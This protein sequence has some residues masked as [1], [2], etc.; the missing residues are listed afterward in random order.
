MKRS[1]LQGTLF[2]MA[3]SGL[4]AAH[5]RA[6]ASSPAGQ[7][8]PKAVAATPSPAPP[9]E[10]AAAGA[11]ARVIY[12]SGSAVY[13]D[14][15]REEGLREGELLQVVRDGGTIA[16][17][18]VAY[19]STHRASCSIVS[20]SA[21]L[22]VGDSV[23]YAPAAGAAGP[24]EV[25]RP[26]PGNGGSPRTAF[27]TGGLRGRIGLRWLAVKDRNG[28]DNG[29]SQSGVDLRLQGHGLARSLLDVEVDART[30]RTYRTS[31]QGDAE[32]DGRTRLYRLALSW[33]P[34]PRLRLSAGRQFAP[35]LASLSIFDGL[36]LDTDGARLG[37]GLLAGYQPDE[38]LGYSSDVREY[39]GYLQFHNAPS[40]RRRWAL[41]TGAI[42]SYTQGTV[43]REFFYLQ[44]QY[45]DSHLSAYLAQEI[46]YN[47]DW[48]VEEANE[49]T[50]SNTSTFA[51]LRVRTGER[52]SV[53]AGYDTRRNV[54]QFRDRVTRVTEFDDSHRQGGWLGASL[55]F[56]GRFQ[57]SL[58]GRTNGGGASGDAGSLSVNLGVDRLTRLGLALHERT[59]RFTNDLTEGWLH[60][61]SAGTS[62]GT[63]V[64]LELSGGTLDETARNGSSLDRS[65]TW[66][67]IDLDIF[68]GRHWYLL[69]SGETNRGDLEKNDQA[70]VSVTYRF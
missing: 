45:S 12:I 39:G 6:S 18:K 28:G 62:L 43:N 2:L 68:L 11:T 3:V 14:A 59:T 70:Y 44:G 10:S 17:L 19:L 67:A 33:H 57:A 5:S 36:L 37:G 65:S 60:S 24:V 35:A 54:R 13:V 20:G 31:A 61:L 64:R 46:D 42:G 38:R 1:A 21:A 51:S 48:K 32:R 34:A 23:H 52:L 4:I 55:R 58:E 53:F 27:G 63:R 22:A 41:T 66:E 47:R 49:P 69:L 7:T 40:G 30:Q 50:L 26:G 25:S 9:R 29:F 16:E 15:G 8:S 56:G